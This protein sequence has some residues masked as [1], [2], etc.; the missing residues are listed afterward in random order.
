M[1]I[2]LGRGVHLH[3]AH[4]MPLP[5]TVS[6]FSKIQISFS[7]LVPDRW[8]GLRQRAVKLVLVMVMVMVVVVVQMSMPQHVFFV[9]THSH[10]STS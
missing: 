8:G 3:M 6:C 5:L 1:V 10:T 9:L 2:C 7:C 4:L